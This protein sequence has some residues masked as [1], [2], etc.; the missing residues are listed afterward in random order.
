MEQNSNQEK[1]LVTSF[2]DLVKLDRDE[3]LTIITLDPDEDAIKFISLNGDI[4][5]V[6]DIKMVKIFDGMIKFYHNYIH[7]TCIK[8]LTDNTYFHIV[9]DEQE[10]LITMIEILNT[11]NAFIYSIEMGAEIQNEYNLSSIIVKLNSDDFSN[12]IV[13]K[14]YYPRNSAIDCITLINNKLR[15]H[16]TFLTEIWDNSLSWVITDKSVYLFNRFVK[17]SDGLFLECNEYDVYNNQKLAI[18]NIS[19][20]ELLLSN[21]T[22]K[23]VFEDN[24]ILV[25]D[26][27]HLGKEPVELNAYQQ[28]NNF[29][30]TVSYPDNPINMIYKISKTFSYYYQENDN[31]KLN[32]Y[33]SMILDYC[34]KLLNCE[35]IKFIEDKTLFETTT[36]YRFNISKELLNHYIKTI[37]EESNYPTLDFDHEIQSEEDNPEPL[38]NI[39]GDQ[40]I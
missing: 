11:N 24:Y 3:K 23:A 27:L 25:G 13:Y 26:E 9:Y 32:H 28:L 1:Y 16:Q 2:T 39:D 40:I 22:L 33:R 34:D 7:I 37:E 21:E 30:L 8:D 29:D 31:D 38:F 14:E 35:L 15:Q 17:N 5:Y 18:K 12:L 10:E 19:L 36:P 4:T 6:T 20:M